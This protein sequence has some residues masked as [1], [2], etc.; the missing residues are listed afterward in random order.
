MTP[1]P[2]SYQVVTGPSAGC[3][4]G[5]RATEAGRRTTRTT[6]GARPGGARWGPSFLEGSWGSRR[7]HAPARHSARRAASRHRGAGASA[8]RPA[9]AWWSLICPTRPVT[10]ATWQLI[11]AQ[12]R[13]TSAGVMFVQ[14][15]TASQSSIIF[16]IAEEEV[17]RFVFPSRGMI[18]LSFTA[19]AN[20]S[21][22]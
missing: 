20:K 22:N 1:R 3:G 18:L 13:R 16:F 21:Y 12:V 8:P 17:L 11:T 5:C 19:T 14:F 7:T 9:S 6:R 4:S 10:A 15:I 2:L